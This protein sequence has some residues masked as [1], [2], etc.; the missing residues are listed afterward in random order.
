MVALQQLFIYG[1]GNQ[2]M[3]GPR[4]ESIIVSLSLCVC[5]CVCVCVSLCV[6]VC[7]TLAVMA[8]ALSGYPTRV[9]VS[10]FHP[11]PAPPSP[12]SAHSAQLV[13]INSDWPNLRHQRLVSVQTETR[14]KPIVEVFRFLRLHQPH[15]PP[16][17]APLADIAR[18]WAI[19]FLFFD[20]YFHSSR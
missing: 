7:V 10:P 1:A 2:L 17:S 9:F 12:H 5:V 14:L 13:L 19:I 8:A 15:P 11:L 4:N 16:P 6:C 18:N 20:D 3:S